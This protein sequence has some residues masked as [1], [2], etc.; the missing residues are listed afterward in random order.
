MHELAITESILK[1]ALESA[2]QHGAKRVRAI[3][4]AI[5]PFSGVVPE[6]VQTHLDVLA[7]GT[8]AEGAKIEARQLPLRVRCRDCG[9]EGEVSRT[10]IEC[11]FCGGLRLE[12]LSGKE[13][14]VEN[15]EVE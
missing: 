6:C 11:P 2:E 8:A 13:C 9:K 1:I 4:L 3:R 14:T 7:K 15:L 10:R 5:G 12:R